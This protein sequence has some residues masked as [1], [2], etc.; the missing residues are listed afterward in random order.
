LVTDETGELYGHTEWGIKELKQRLDYD[1]NVAMRNDLDKYAD[2][3]RPIQTLAEG[4]EPNENWYMEAETFDAE[5]WWEEYRDELESVDPRTLD[6][7]EQREFKRFQEMKLPKA[8]AM[9]MLINSVEGDY[10]QLSPRLAKVAQKQ[11]E[12]GDWSGESFGAE[13]EM[14]DVDCVNVVSKKAAFS[15]SGK[16]FYRVSFRD[17][18]RYDRFAVPAWARKAAETMGVKYYDVSG[19]MITMGQLPSGKWEIQAVLIPNTE[20]MTK[21]KALKMGNHMQD[22]IE[23]EGEWAKKKCREN[24]VVEIYEAESFGADKKNCGCGKDP[25]VTYGVEGFESQAETRATLIS[26]G[27]VLATVGVG[28]AL[29]QTVFKQK[30]D[31]AMGKSD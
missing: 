15:G 3:H 27:G 10:S 20:N 13:M 14:A 11:E 7:F 2:L 26:I 1:L 19:C 21:E 6:M 16:N 12:S 29:F 25:C 18:N 22:R 31:D 17:K 23:R 8:K 4:D 5:E 30:L 9:Q 24:E 28:I